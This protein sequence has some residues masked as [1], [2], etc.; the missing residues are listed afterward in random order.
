[1]RGSRPNGPPEHVKYATA[2]SPATVSFF[3]R[4][5]PC[6]TSLAGRCCAWAARTR[7]TA[8]GYSIDAVQVCRTWPDRASMGHRP[9]GAGASQCVCTGRAFT[10]EP[11]ARS[12]R[13]TSDRRRR[14]L[15]KCRLRISIVGA[16]TAPDVRQLL[17][18]R[19]ITC[20]R[21][22]MWLM[23]E[24]TAIRLYGWGHSPSRTT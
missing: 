3:S 10:S 19:D 8:K 14:M 13:M 2:A 22:R 11:Q 24:I 21:K 12:T 15:R 5:M 16:N 20:H 1:M 17:P 7:A 4:A 23:G 6:V 18:F 9:M